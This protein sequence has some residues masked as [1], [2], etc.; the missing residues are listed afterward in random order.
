LAKPQLTGNWKNGVL[1]GSGAGSA[2]PLSGWNLTNDPGTAWYGSMKRPADV[3]D[4]Y[5]AALAAPKLDPVL[6]QKVEDSVFNDDTVIPMWF[7]T[8]NWIVADNVMDSGLC[9]RDLFAWFES[10]NAWLK[11]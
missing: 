5:K 10:Q 3:A 4:L 11:K 9:T 6:C 1:F 2:N 8:T 7:S